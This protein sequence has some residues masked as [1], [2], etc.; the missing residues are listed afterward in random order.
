[1]KIKLLISVLSAIL[2]VFFLAIDLKAGHDSATD[3]WMSFG[4]GVMAPVCLAGLI[5]TVML[6]RKQKSI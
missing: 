2:F 4:M 5:S 1:M 3:K 6:Y